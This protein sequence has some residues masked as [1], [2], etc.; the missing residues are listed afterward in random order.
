MTW[1]NE[2]TCKQGTLRTLEWHLFRHEAHSII[3]STLESTGGRW[4][5]ISRS[6]PIDCSTSV[7]LYEYVKPLYNVPLYKVYLYITLRKGMYLPIQ[8]A[9]ITSPYNVHL[10]LT[11]TG[12][13]SQRERYIE[14]SLYIHNQQFYMTLQ[15][16]RQCYLFC[17]GACRIIMANFLWRR[18]LPEFPEDIFIFISFLQAAS[19]K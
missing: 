8:M 16:F 19:Q 11:Y 12:C 4:S 17:L 9:W 6:S 15:R 7:V 1:L 2:W 14:V 5:W 18:A 10:L 13:L 3:H